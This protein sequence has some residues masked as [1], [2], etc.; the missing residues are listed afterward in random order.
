M[1]ILRHLKKLRPDIAM[2]QE[3][4]LGEGDLSRMKKLWV[5]TVYG[6]PA[7]GN[8][9][10]VLTLIHK[11]FPHTLVSHDTDE[12]G[13][14]SHLVID[15]YGERLN[16]FNVYGPNGENKEFFHELGVRVG[17]TRSENT[18][19]GGD[20]NTVGHPSEERQAETSS[21]RNTPSRSAD[22]VLP[23]FLQDTGL[24]DC[25]RDSHPDSREYT[26]YSHAHKS[27]SRIDLLLL[28]DGLRK[29]L[30]SA[31]IENMVISDHSPVCVT[32]WETLPRGTDIIWRFPAHLT[33]NEG[34]RTLLQGWW[35]EFLSDN[36]NHLGSPPLLWAT[37]KAV[38]RGR[39][40]GYV[41]S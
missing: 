28:S 41:N 12:E 22:R 15:H 20:F 16:L 25:W 30:Q 31:D 40:M 24:S 7:Q 1:Q 21:E 23:P 14:I 29:R 4:H 8:R 17:C 27:W 39:I 36:K 13:R 10:G 26:H 38:L 19:V 32:L 33:R 3:T 37:A 11:H 9:A 2:L 5:G 35:L 34:F 18:L 6:S